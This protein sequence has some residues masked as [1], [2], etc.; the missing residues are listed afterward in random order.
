MFDGM[1]ITFSCCSGRLQLLAHYLTGLLPPSAGSKYRPAQPG[2]P[3]LMVEREQI[4]GL[5]PSR[6][7]CILDRGTE[8]FTYTPTTKTWA[9][10]YTAEPRSQ[11]FATLKV[12]NAE[13]GRPERL[14]IR[15]R[16]PRNRQ[17]VS[18]HVRL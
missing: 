14:S 3:R 18:I 11:V 2:I 6:P 9:D 16:N 4:E 8:G 12:M 5:Y 17:L 7:G 10:K 1:A 15:M 13:S